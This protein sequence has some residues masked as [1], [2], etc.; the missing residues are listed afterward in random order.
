M[1]YPTLLW[2]CVNDIHE[3]DV[4]TYCSVSTN[5]QPGAYE[6]RKAARRSVKLSVVESH[7]Q[8]NSKYGQKDGFKIS[9]PKWVGNY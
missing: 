6:R 5:I 7:F 8:Q 1:V 3:Q 4:H 2:V 9:V